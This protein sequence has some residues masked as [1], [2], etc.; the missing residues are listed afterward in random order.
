MSSTQHQ[1]IEQCATR[2]R[3]I[4]EA[5]D[6]IHDNTPRRWSTELDDVHS[7]AESLLALIK[8]QAPAR[9]E[10]SFEEWLANELEGED[11]QPV[12]A[13]VCDIALARRAF[14]HWPKLEQPAKVG[15]V[16]F[17]AGVSSRLVVE[18]AQRLY[19]FESTPE[20]EAERIERLQAFREQLDPLNLAP[21]AKAFNEAPAEALKSEQA[22]A[23]LEKQ[24]PVGE[25]R[26]SGGTLTAVIVRHSYA[27][28]LPV[29]TKLYAAPVAQAQ[30]LHDLDKQCRDDVAR[31]L[32]LRPSQ[33]RGFAWSYL[34]ASIKSCVKA[35]EDAAQ[36][37][38]SVPEGWKLVPMDPTSQM[39]FVGQSLRY[40]AVNSIGEIYRQMLAAAPGKEVPQAWLDIQAERRR[41]VEAEGWTPEHDDLYC[42]AEL[43][44]AAAAY[45][46]NGANDEA[47]AIWPFVAKWWK[48][49]DARSNYVRAGALILAEIE[50]LDRAEPGKEGM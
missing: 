13:A 45:I 9:S 15:G 49:R 10:A 23:E 39:T 28:K 22:E 4:V 21:H 41:Q 36:A 47:P 43:P 40:D 27:T 17:S 5:L 34:L 12:P 33:E 19:E 26:E 25:V 31:A 7:S 42:A 11:G 50:R 2:L 30:Q 35:S 37:Q 46:L 8:D 32:G 3:G 14:N 29:G 20:Q 38:H 44:R 24:E 1:L 16:R 18:A 6:N 48:P